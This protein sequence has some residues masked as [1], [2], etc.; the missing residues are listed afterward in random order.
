VYALGALRR[1]LSDLWDEAL[2]VIVIGL[3]GGLFSLP[4]LTI[5]LVLAAHYNAALR[6]S[7]QRVV[8]IRDWFRLSR[9]HLRFFV[10]W[11]LL[12]TLVGV[13]LAGNVLFYLRLGPEW[14]RLLAWSIAGLFFTWILP[15]PFVPAFYLQQTDRRLRTA[16]H[17]TM[18]LIV[19]DPSSI[20]VLWLSAAVLA[21]PLAY[22]AWPLLPA[23]MPFIVLVSTRIVKGYAQPEA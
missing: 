4:I 15:Q 17:N 22:F 5:P 18:V 12:A 10:M 6:I 1:A 9:E 23:L 2:L 13:I 11:A 21:V 16:L 3:L 19:T 20:V 7:E 8:S 14:A